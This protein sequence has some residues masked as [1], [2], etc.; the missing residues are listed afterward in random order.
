MTSFLFIGITS[1]CSLPET[2]VAK[3]GM[4]LDHETA[5]P[6]NADETEQISDAVGV[7]ATIT[8]ALANA[9]HALEGAEAELVLNP[10]RLAF[11]TKNVK[12]LE[13]AL[14]CLHVRACFLKSILF[15]DPSVWYGES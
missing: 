1:P 8:T 11:E 5:V 7:R 12:V 6:H 13:L 4:E 9:G 10:L 3:S 14:D 2:G 15:C